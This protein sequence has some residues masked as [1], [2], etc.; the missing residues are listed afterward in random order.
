MEKEQFEL[1]SIWEI[2]CSD[3][4]S[5]SSSNFNENN[6]EKNRKIFEKEIKE[7][8]LINDPQEESQKEKFQRNS[9]K[10]LSYHS[11]TLS[12]LKRKT[13]CDKQYIDENEFNYTKK[14][15]QSKKSF[16]EKNG[17]IIN[18]NENYHNSQINLNEKI[19]SPHHNLKL[20]DI[21]HLLLEFDSMK[22]YKIYFPYNNSNI[23]I[24]S[25][26][27][28]P[29]LMKNTRKLKRKIHS[30]LLSPNISKPNS[31][32]DLITKSQNI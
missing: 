6:N 12:N 16:K 18:T 15:K 29:C 14:Q 5:D 21:F 27:Q 30:N 31:D 4:S 3:E 22:N 24:R 8:Y 13:S 26:K 28:T 23:V 20:F 7:S 11:P 25:M 9:K 10:H 17:L 2:S 19:F 32:Q 1:G